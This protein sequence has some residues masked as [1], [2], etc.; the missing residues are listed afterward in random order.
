MVAALAACAVVFLAASAETLHARRCRKV[1]ALVFG[2]GRRPAPW[3]YLAPP[4]RVAAL[5][6]LT[7]GLVTLL[8]LP[9]KVRQAG[10]LAENEYRNLLLVL[11]VSPS[12]RLQ[13]AG[14]AGKQSRRQRAA[15]VLQ[16]FFARIPVDHYRTTVLATYTDCKPVVVATTDLEIVRNILND[17]PME[18]AFK[19]GATDIF[20]GLEQAAKVA[21]PWRPKSTILMVVTDGDTV[22]ATGLPKL[23]DSIDSVVLVGVGDVLA[24]RSIAGHKSRQDASTL[25]QLAVRLGGTYHNG[26]EKQLPMELLTRITAVPGQSV[27]ERLT[28]REYALAA[29]AAG[30]AVLALLPVLLHYAGTLYTP[31]LRLGRRPGAAAPGRQLRAVPVPGGVR[32]GSGS[33]SPPGGAGLG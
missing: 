1:A 8:L 23:P 17:L 31:G 10:V 14:P 9:P 29:V 7:W 18:Q 30:A 16:S 12:M 27:F 6:A 33:P 28:L 13:D 21:R 4:L 20:T 32:I 5:A 3:V 2:P 15:D 22:P 24:G 25:R 19:S 26:N 11:D